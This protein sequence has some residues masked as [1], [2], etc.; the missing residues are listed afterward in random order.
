[1][2]V[3][4]RFKLNDMNENDIMYEYEIK[5][6]AVIRVDKLFSRETNKK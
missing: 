1:M 6:H 5:C 3:I 4:E 2:M